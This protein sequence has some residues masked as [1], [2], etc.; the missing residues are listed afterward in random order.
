MTNKPDKLFGSINAFAVR[1]VFENDPDQGQGATEEES[2]SWGSFEI[3]INNKNLCLYMYDGK[4]V[5]SVHWYLI[6]LIEWFAKNLDPLLHE[7]RLPN[8]NDGDNAWES[9]ANTQ[10]PPDQYDENKEDQWYGLWRQWWLRHC[11]QSCR[12][13]GM[14]PDVVI[15]RFQ[16]MVEISWGKGKVVDKGN[17]SPPIPKEPRL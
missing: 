14:F 2:V 16:D 5:G 10:H 1:L 6:A 3:W 13:G 8:E 17:A 9:L 15:R 7:E 4:P 11:L 12:C